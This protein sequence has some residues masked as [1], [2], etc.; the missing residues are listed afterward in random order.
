MRAAVQHGPRDLRIEE[1][2]EPACGHGEIKVKVTYCGVCGTDPE[3]YEGT[4]GLM[5]TA[6]WPKGPKTEGHEA[7]GTIAELGPGCRQGYQV[8]QRVA[9]NFRAACGACWYCRNKMEHFCTDVSIATGAFAEYAV[10]KESCVYPLPDALSMERGALLEPLSVVVHTIDLADIQPGRAVAI[11]GAGTLGLMLVQVAIRAGA[12]KVLVS[13]PVAAKRELA[14]RFGADVAIDPTSEDLVAAGRQLTDGRGFGTVI[15]ASGNLRAAEQALTLA[16]NGATV[17]WAAVYPDE[18][19]VAVNPFH[20]YAT[21]MTIRAVN[22]SP[23]SFPRAMELL[24]KL[25]LE[26]I[27]T[28]IRPLA[29]LDDVLRTFRTNPSI[30]TLIAL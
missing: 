26:P 20:M 10:Y 25:D 22:V 24:P 13:E 28:S 11:S 23:Y 5:K 2:A 9:M 27:V 18:A 21:E 19:T 29:E 12:T 1:V 7:C 17:V 15:E 4:F 30:K 16:G 8:G 6:G 3:I 14:L